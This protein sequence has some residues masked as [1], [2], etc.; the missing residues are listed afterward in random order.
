MATE[1]TPKPTMQQSIADLTGK[2]RTISAK[3]L[4]HFGFIYLSLILVGITAVIYLVGQTMQ[5]SDVG[6]AAITKEKEGEYTTL[7]LFD[8]TTRMQIKNLSDDNNSTATL[9]HGRIN[10]FSESVY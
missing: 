9:P 10:P 7:F 2:L 5:S 3:V 8:P 6:N 4:P 1:N